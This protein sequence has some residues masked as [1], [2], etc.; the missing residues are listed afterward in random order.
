MGPGLDC[1]AG[2]PRMAGGP[3]A[4]PVFI[5]VNP[6]STPWHDD[7]LQLAARDRARGVM[8]PKAEDASLVH[9]LAGKLGPREFIPL[10]ETVAGWYGA[11]ELAWAPVV[12]RLA[13]GNL[14]WPARPA[15]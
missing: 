2:D 11:L 13:L 5:R 4:A 12:T 15:R 7:D 10:V 3:R 9:A 1:V 6:Q 8:L 14:D